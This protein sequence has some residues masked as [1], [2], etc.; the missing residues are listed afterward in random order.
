MRPAAAAAGYG[1]ARARQADGTLACFGNNSFGQCDAL[2]ALGPVAAVAEGDHRACV[3]KANGA[4]VCFGDNGSGQCEVPAGYL[5]DHPVAA[6][7]D[8][9]LFST[10]VGTVC[11]PHGLA[12]AAVARPR[13]L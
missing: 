5:G 4:L 12:H 11:V 10:I 9:R 6:S 3:L 2:A 8:D 7:T 1:H 13:P